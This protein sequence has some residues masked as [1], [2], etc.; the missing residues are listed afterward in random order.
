MIKYKYSYSEL[1]CLELATKVALLK[2][3]V[4]NDLSEYRNKINA[5]TYNQAVFLKTKM[6]HLYISINSKQSLKNIFDWE[7]C[8][9]YV[10]KIISQFKKHQ[11][12]IDTSNI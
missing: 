5:S 2:V 9:L 4:E 8:W 11:H 10:N 3:S 12:G 6:D 7:N 1:Q